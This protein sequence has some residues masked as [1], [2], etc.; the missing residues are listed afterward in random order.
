[1][2]GHFTHIYTAR[3]VSDHL[4][5]GEFPD[6]PQEASGIRKFDPVHCGT[7]MRTW[8]KYTAIGAI[9]P[10]LFYFSQDYN[11]EP[12][13]PLS[14]DIMLML[15]KQREDDRT[16]D[17]FTPFKVA[18]E[19]GLLLGISARALSRLR[20]GMVKQAHLWSY[21]RKGG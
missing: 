11:G 3:R 16:W 13:G 17:H 21:L 12:L 5:D 7:V 14:D 1:M 9:G 8:E 15:Q 2:P 4:I 18:T 10:D 20:S 6:W 19:P